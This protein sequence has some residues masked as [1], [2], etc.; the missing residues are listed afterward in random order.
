ML[1]INFVYSFSILA[2]PMT[3]E[4]E[5]SPVIKET[6]TIKFS[7]KSYIWNLSGNKTQKNWLC[8]ERERERECGEDCFA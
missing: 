5:C 2:N 3:I 4:K 1:D 8:V 6:I 7:R